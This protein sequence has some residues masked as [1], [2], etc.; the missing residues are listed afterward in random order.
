MP[1][2][3]TKRV[4]FGVRQQKLAKDPIKGFQQHWF[5]DNGKG[6]IEAAEAAGYEFVMG[7]DGQ[8][9]KKLVGRGEDGK[10]MN[11]YLMKLPDEYAE[12]D[13]KAKEAEN[14]KVDEAIRRGQIDNKIEADKA[15]VP[16]GG[17]E[18]SI[19]PKP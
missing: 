16:K 10:G 13:R 15:Y 14:A 3:R 18:I 17:I 11:A 12:E 5:N 9:V 4:P 8:K 1:K 6:R 19:S 7:P 2:D